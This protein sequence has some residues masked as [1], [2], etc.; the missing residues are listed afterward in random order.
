MPATAAAS[1]E[2][3]LVEE[4]ATYYAD[5][6]GFVLAMFP[7]GEPGQLEHDQGP[8]T[9]QREFLAW[10]GEQV[11]ANKFDGHS[12]VAPLRAGASSGHGI[13]KSVLVALVTLWIMSTRP[14]AQGTIT[15]N[16]ITQLKTKTWAA[17]RRWTKLCKTGHWFE[18]NA[19]RMYHKQFPES[20]YCAQQSSKEEN[21][22][23][24]AGQHAKDSSSFY[25]FDEASAIPDVIHEV[26]EG[27][28]TDGEPMFFQFGNATRSHGKF[29]EA[30]FGKMRH[31]WRQWI[32]DSRESRFTNKAQIAEWAQD[33]GED[34]DFFR[35]RVL[36]LPPNA[37]DIQFIGNDLVRKAQSAT[38]AVLP[39]E[40]LVCGVDLARGGSDECVIR[41]RVGRDARSI[42]ARRVPGEQARD[43]MKMATMLADMLN[44]TYDGRK[45]HTMFVDATGGSIGGP[46]ADRLRQ[47]GHA[48]VVD[49]QFG[50]ENPEPKEKLANMRAYMWSKLRNALA[51]GLAIDSSP[52]LETDLTG[53]GYRHD[54]QDNILIESKEDM[55]KRGLDSPDDGDAL[56]L[57]FAQQVVARPTPVT[58][59]VPIHVGDG[60]FMAM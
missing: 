39:D 59:E 27:G 50:G 48:N 20:W 49:V 57:T 5:P 40:P 43:S 53:P 7:W 24:F 25:I 42:P 29:H 52:Q 51:A 22:E 32:I 13:G 14:H 23:A 56:A 44:Q 17:L 1:Y 58:V 54:K 3:L 4:V 35:V 15:A 21:S 26:A 33:Y 34:S 11:K 19:E 47:L 55:K 60:A 36:G 37:S 45:I 2:Q 41:F 46:I 38:V 9:W 28:L 6:L 16:T 10:L 18:I 30:M 31:R 12:P 8:D